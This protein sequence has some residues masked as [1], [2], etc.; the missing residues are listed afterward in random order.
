MKCKRL[1]ILGK[2][3]RGTCPFVIHRRSTCSLGSVDCIGA[4]DRTQCPA[5]LLE[6]TLDYS[7]DSLRLLDPPVEY[8]PPV[9]QWSDFA[10]LQTPPFDFYP[11]RIEHL[12]TPAAGAQEDINQWVR[13]SMI[14]L[15]HMQMYYGEKARRKYNKVL[16]LG[17]DAFVPRASGYSGTSNRLIKASLC[18]W[19]SA[20]K[21]IHNGI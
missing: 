1:V 5:E 18:L 19:T 6:T 2:K 3:S 15:V 11:I 4:P 14:V 13:R 12:L 20:N 7:N 9:T 8:K 17:Q 10:P 16:A 21:L